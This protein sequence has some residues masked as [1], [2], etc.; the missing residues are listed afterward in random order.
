LEATSASH[1]IWHF[2]PIRLFILNN[3]I[4]F[5]EMPSIK[6]G[7]KIIPFHFPRFPHFPRP[8]AS[9]PGSSKP[10]EQGQPSNAEPPTARN[11]EPASNVTDASDRH[12]WKAPSPITPTDAGMTMLFNPL[13]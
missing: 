5:Y 2:L 9:D 6:S 4:Y 3:S 12:P 1:P 10:S 13:Y 8:V 11:A 7:I